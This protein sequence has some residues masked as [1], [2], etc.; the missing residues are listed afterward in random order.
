M[1]ATTPA[2]APRLRVAVA[3]VGA[4]L[5]SVAPTFAQRSEV[6]VAPPFVATLSN[7]TPLAFGMDANQAATALGMPLNYVSGKP[8]D[9]VFLVIRTQG[10]TGFFDRRDRL[11]LQFRR[12]R[13]AGW[14]GDWGRNWMW[15]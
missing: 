11:Y 15:R 14:K 13:L 8:G 7:T 10:G 9:E 3:T 4:L 5:L 6:I 12:G 2:I 1:T